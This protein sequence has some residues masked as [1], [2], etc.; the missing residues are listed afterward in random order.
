L[1]QH[2]PSSLVDNALNNFPNVDKEKGEVVQRVKKWTDL[3]ASGHSKRRTFFNQ[4]FFPGDQAYW[5]KG[6]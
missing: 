6:H 4:Y 1:S 2:I 5:L 3:D